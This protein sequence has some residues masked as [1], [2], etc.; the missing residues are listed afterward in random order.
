MSPYPR[1]FNKISVVLQ[2]AT[3]HGRLSF[4]FHLS[5]RISDCPRLYMIS[6][7]PISHSTLMGRLSRYS[8]SKYGEFVHF[9][10]S[11]KL[12]E[13]NFLDDQH[14]HFFR[15]Q[16]INTDVDI[17]IDDFR[18]ELP[19]ASLFPASN[20]ICNEL[21]VNGNAEILGPSHYPMTTLR[22]SSYLSVVQ[23][24]GSSN[25]YFR[26][27]QRSDQWSSMI[28]YVDTNCLRRGDTY[29]FS[30][31]VRIHS[32]TARAYK[33]RLDSP[34]YEIALCPPQKYSDGWVTCSEEFTVNDRVQDFTSPLKWQFYFVDGGITADVDYDDV[35]LKNLGYVSNLVVAKE[36][37]R[38]WGEGSEVHIGSSV[39]YSFTNEMKNGDTAIIKSIHDNNDGTVS[40]ELDPDTAPTIPIITSEDD[41]TYAADVALVSR[42]VVIEGES[43]EENKGEPLFYP[44]IICTL[45]RD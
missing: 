4:H 43:G 37:A 22:S 9:T 18:I 1:W 30:M 11:F 16:D 33:I 21:I 36:D 38:C 27:T 20:E 40:L 28:S 2:I 45:S 10:G 23:D 32:E 12:H 7:G 34:H 35:S 3:S 6:Y 14:T 19:P 13:N 24:E 39:F 26:L 29:L 42:N 8:D 15:I 41:P 25:S 17:T 31:K 5:L 44:S